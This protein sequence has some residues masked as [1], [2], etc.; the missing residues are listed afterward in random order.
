MNIMTAAIK[1]KKIFILNLLAKRNDMN[2]ESN[3][4]VQFRISNKRFIT[5][6]SQTVIFPFSFEVALKI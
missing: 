5:V 2:I 6:N 3:K 4:T 1:G